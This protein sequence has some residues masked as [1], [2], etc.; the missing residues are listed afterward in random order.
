MKVDETYHFLLRLT[1]QAAQM[2][3]GVHVLGRCQ[4]EHIDFWA[5][6][7][8]EQIEKLNMGHGIPL[9]NLPEA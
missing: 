1:N 3:A 2:N 4:P 8:A 6:K 9:L 5:N 7:V